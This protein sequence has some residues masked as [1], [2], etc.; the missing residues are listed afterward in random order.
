MPRKNTTVNQE[1]TKV[2]HTRTPKLYQKMTVYVEH[3]N[4]EV[5]K[6]TVIADSYMVATAEAEKKYN[7]VVVAVKSA[8][9]IQFSAAE[10]A[11][12]LE[13]SGMTETEQTIITIA[14]EK[15]GVIEKGGDE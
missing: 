5:T 2:A 9:P 10:M 7:G 14:L 15:L 12:K 8:E 6:H 11:Y 4:E 1:V 3:E 13:N